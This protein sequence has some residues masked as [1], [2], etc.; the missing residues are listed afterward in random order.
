MLWSGRPKGAI[1]T[2]S[3][4]SYKS[5]QSKT[6]FFFLYC[7][8]VSFDVDVDVRVLVSLMIL[9]PSTATVNC[10]L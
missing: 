4:V 5:S 10:E 7:N 9:D 2:S 8:S 3:R 1:V 6:R